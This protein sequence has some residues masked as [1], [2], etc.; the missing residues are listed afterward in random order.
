M[1]NAKWRKPSRWKSNL[2]IITWSRLFVVYTILLLFLSFSEAH[3]LKLKAKSEEEDRKLAEQ[4]A[5]H[6]T[7]VKQKK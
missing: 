7:P 3:A 5:A 4:I 1:N 2:F 6:G